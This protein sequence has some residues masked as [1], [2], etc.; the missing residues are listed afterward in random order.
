LK[1][2]DA[3]S[4]KTKRGKARKVAMQ[5]QALRLVRN[6]FRM[7]DIGGKSSYNVAN[8]SVKLLNSERAKL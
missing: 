5:A 1:K 8:I 2:H 6:W 4:Q 7:R 3:M